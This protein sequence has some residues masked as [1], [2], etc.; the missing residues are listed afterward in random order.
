MKKSTLKV[1]MTLLV[2]D[3]QDI[4]ETN[5]DYH[6]SQGVDLFIITDNLSTDNTSRILDDYAKRG[7]AIIINES[8]DDYCQHKWV[9][10]MAKIAAKDYHADW[11]INSDAD[12]FWMPNNNSNTIKQTLENVRQ[13]TLA[14]KIDRVNFLPPSI[15][16]EN[17]FFAE[18]MQIRD[19]KSYNSLGQPLP[20]K[21]CHRGFYDVSIKQGNHHVLKGGK[22]LE[23]ES[24]PMTILH[25]PLR[26]YSQFEN[27]IKKGG[28]AY[29]R[30][31][32]LDKN[33][34]STW[35]DLY[36]QYLSGRLFDYYL[37]QCSDSE[38]IYSTK[39]L[40]TN[41]FIYDKRLIKYISEKLN[42]N[43]LS[44]QRKAINDK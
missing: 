43:K 32:T 4:I 12:E 22:L 3:E 5:I 30:N 31:T 7:A 10:R 42:Y 38:K 21:I 18:N 35:R 1:I 19:V 14:C 39:H 44:N 8:S 33:I 29:E 40:N 28:A 26:S 25:F 27:K 6:L 15:T 20:P 13:D 2:R 11:V 37:Q 9:T 34:G 36:K 23:P 17:H 24:I 41:K 16:C